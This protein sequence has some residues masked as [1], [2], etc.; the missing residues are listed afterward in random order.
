MSVSGNTFEI[1]DVVSY[2]G[3]THIGYN[4]YVVVS[5]YG[6]GSYDIR[7]D[8]GLEAELDPDDRWINDVDQGQL[9]LLRRP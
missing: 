1:G 4:V 8:N 5:D 7:L 2:S 3:H 6:N 9:T